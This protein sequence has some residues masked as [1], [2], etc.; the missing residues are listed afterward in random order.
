MDSVR[1]WTVV[2]AANPNNLETIIKK[3]AYVV[4]PPEGPKPPTAEQMRDIVAAS[5][6]RDA[7]AAAAA[8]AVTK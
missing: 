4:Y 7:A 6:R 3:F 8:A 5:R 2:V 1:P